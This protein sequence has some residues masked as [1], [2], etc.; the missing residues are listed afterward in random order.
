MDQSKKHHDASESIHTGQSDTLTQQLQ[1]KL[2]GNSFGAGSAGSMSVEEAR[3]AGEQIDQGAAQEKDKGGRAKRAREEARE[4]SP[5]AKRARSDSSN[6]DSASPFSHLT[7]LAGGK[8]TGKAKSKVKFKAKGKA[9]SSAKGK[10]KS[11]A[12]GA[13]TA[14]QTELRASFDEKCH[15]PL[16]PLIK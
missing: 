4:D 6:E 8:T 1:K 11:S 13:L 7:V 14:K 10:A 16:P 2:I 5:R 15:A 3:V 9:T 12:D